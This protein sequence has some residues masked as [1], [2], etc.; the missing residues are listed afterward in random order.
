[1]NYIYRIIPF[2]ITAQLW[3]TWFN[4]VPQS[5]TQPNGR[6]I[7][8]FASGDQ[9]YHRLHDEN[10]YTIVLNPENGF[11][12]Y[13][14]RDANNI[15][16]SEHI[17]GESDPISLGLESNIVLSQ[18]EYLDKRNR[19]ESQVSRDG[20]DAPTSGVIEQINIFIKFADDPD[21]PNPRSYYDDVF[22]LEN[23]PSLK[24]YYREVSYNTLQVNTHQYPGTI[25]DVNT[26][27]IDDHNRA[28]YQPFSDA[29]PIGYQTDAQRT[30]REQTL[31]KHAV[32]AISSQVPLDLDIDANNDGYVDAVSFVIYGNPD[33]WAELLW[34][35][36]WSLY[37]ETV[38][39]H[40]ARVWDYL[41][42]LSESWYFNVGV[43]CH[44][45]FHVLGA[46]DLYHYTDTGAPTAVGG[47]DIMESTSQPPQYMSAFMKYKYG[48]WFESIPEITESGTYTLNPLQSPENALYKI[49]SPN[50]EFEYFVVEY[51]KKE[52]IYEVNTPGNRSGLVVYRINTLAGDGNASG[53]P[54]EIYVYRPGGTLSSNGNFN[55]APYSSEYNHT[56]LND[57]TN[58]S[59]FLYNNGLGAPGG[60]NI[61]DVGEAGETISFSVSLGIPELTVSPESL[62]IALPANQIM[63][64]SFNVSNDGDDG[65]NVNYNITATDPP[66]FINPTH[67]PDGGNYFV[68][69]STEEPQLA[70][71][72]IDIAG[73]G[74]EVIFEHND[75]SSGPYALPFSFPFYD[76]EQTQ[77]II[78]PNGW[79][80]FGEDNSDWSNIE[81][82]SSE[83][84]NPAILGFWDDLNPVNTAG[85]GSPSGHVYYHMDEDRVVV[86]YDQ[87]VR[88]ST[89]NPGTFD[90]QIVLYSDG[91]FRVN[92]REMNGVVNSAT[93]GFQSGDGND[94]ILIGY[95]TPLPANDTFTW[96]IDRP[97]ALSWLSLDGELTGQL[98]GGESSSFATIVNTANMDIGYYQGSINII[99]DGANS[100]MVPV[101]LTVI[102][103]DG[104]TPSLPVLDISSSENGVITLPNWVNPLFTNVF[105]RYT[106]L[107]ANNGHVIPILIQNNATIEQI[108]HVKK[109]LTSHLTDQPNLEWGSQKSAVMDSLAQSNAI[110]FLLNNEDEYENPDI[111]LLIDAGIE[112]Q[113]VLAIE[114]FPEST[115]EYIMSTERDAT[116]E[117]ILHFVHGF[118]IQRAL[119]AY[120]DAL[121]AAM[122]EA[123]ENNIYN[124]LWDLPEED[125]DEEYLAMGFECY[126][127][128]WSHDPN[129]DG[130]C[131]DH[132]YAF[133]NRD[134]MEVG[135]PL[136]F[137]L[138]SNFFGET[139]EYEAIWAGPGGL[140]F[141][142][143]REETLDY[144]YR[145]QYLKNAKMI[146]ES[147]INLI[148][149]DFSN[150]LIGNDGNNTISGYGGNDILVGQP[151]NEDVAGFQGVA[152]EY[153]I[154]EI[155]ETEDPTYLIVDLIVGRDDS[156]T[157]IN[158]QLL[159]FGGTLYD[160]QSLL[161]LND[162][163]LVPTETKL[164]PAYPNPF[165]PETTIRYHLTDAGWTQINIFDLLGRPVRSLVNQ[166]LPAGKYHI[167][168]D[169]K[170]DA[171][172]PMSAGLYFFQLQ[173]RSVIETQKIILLK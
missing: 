107:P 4:D 40:G 112:G 80:G 48:D 10:G 118:G 58:P 60:L 36:R 32:E 100:V 156:T 97:N 123:I 74:T 117:E 169:G 171:L 28:Y 136:L 108:H 9:Y 30:E 89:S 162:P 6:V 137:D 101:S 147:S 165:N 5:I 66:Q 65:S 124:P 23:E 115:S 11:F 46:P 104:Q 131:G 64:E 109:V 102:D 121:M 140:D 53:P 3:A 69:Y 73:I 114:I 155:R 173:S 119:P 61:Y 33:G 31:L 59:C 52:G 49:S 130:W 167:K 110:I 170:N 42:M 63:N 16:P 106:H 93:V 145:S 91:D 95:N 51:R 76:E 27:Y 172:M 90:F 150:I 57:G 2:L 26:S 12:V 152:S 77:F 37:S 122:N 24:H 8:C 20:R 38:Y 166:H 143:Q 99:G 67:G 86:W 163:R 105:E 151:D 34:P 44:E 14:G 56:E 13:A 25:T 164:F 92:Y 18:A 116:Y 41:F 82:P 138:I 142:I 113:D 1:M 126:F 87:V 128:L 103:D 85:G 50:S 83:G 141:F 47:W 21:F 129:N 160:L 68:A 78:N 19:F 15:V 148:G 22:N 62:N 125:Y 146:G 98:N 168:W 35:H 96:A 75:V 127:G 88:W 159:N 157:I 135:D 81:I 84:P 111:E 29:N 7:E 154:E 17:V 149:N 158:I 55:S 139:M 39:I 94:G 161:D 134:M 71:N 144:T 72:W 43:L 120:Q 45:F 133:I 70:Y 79:V 54:D 153:A 132:E